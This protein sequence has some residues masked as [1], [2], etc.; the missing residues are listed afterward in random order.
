M[1]YVGP[2]VFACGFSNTPVHDVRSDPDYS[3]IKAICYN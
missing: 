3:G 2:G 1:Q